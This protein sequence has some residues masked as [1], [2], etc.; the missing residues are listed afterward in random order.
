MLIRKIVILSL[1]SISLLAQNHSE[2]N[3]GFQKFIN[4]DELP[5]TDVS[6]VDDVHIIVQRILSKI[7]LGQNFIL[8]KCDSLNN[9]IAFT[10]T[11][12]IRYISYDEH[13]LAQ[14][15]SHKWTNHFVL[16]HE[17]GHHLLGHTLRKTNSL[18]ESRKQE[19]EAD[20]FAGFACFL[21]DAPLEKLVYTF[22]KFPD[23]DNESLSSHPV[24]NKRIEALKAGYNKARENRTIN[25]EQDDESAI[26]ILYNNCIKGGNEIDSRMGDCIEAYK[27][28]KGDSWIEL[29]VSAS[30]IGGN[31]KAISYSTELINILPSSDNYLLRA[32]AKNAI[33][34]YGGALDDFDVAQRI[35]DSSFSANDHLVRGDIYF[36]KN[37]ISEALTEYLLCDKKNV[38]SKEDSEFWAT[39]NYEPSM[40]SDL[41]SYLYSMSIIYASKN[42]ISKSIFYAEKFLDKVTVNIEK[43]LIPSTHDLLGDLY[44]LS[45]KN[46]S[47]EHYNKSCLADSKYC[48]KYNIRC[49]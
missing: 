12:G 44:N 48:S 15:A 22:D 49:K 20:N 32:H 4:S 7:G 28:M 3:C 41:Y 9:A 30:I 25:I 40:P 33:G 23:I 6:K 13:F 43:Q 18:A 10:S 24:K 39:Y 45:N 1:F 11:T 34:D 21:I 42:E 17:V 46:K 2:H 29:I 31:N 35:D 19:L 38:I 47:C 36:S 27:H 26:E 16:A 37:R 5:C 14:L 8:S